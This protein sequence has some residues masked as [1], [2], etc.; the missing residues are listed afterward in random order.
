MEGNGELSFDEFFSE[1]F[2]DLL[3]PEVVEASANF[4]EIVTAVRHAKSEILPCPR[5]G[6]YRSA[7]AKRL[8]DEKEKRNIR[9]RERRAK[10]KKVERELTKLL[11][12]FAKKPTK[13]KLLQTA[14]KEIQIL[15]QAVL[16]LQQ[17]NQ[18][19]EMKLWLKRQF[20]DP[21]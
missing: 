13:L 17:D 7:K 9:E 15:Q 8:K 3:F 14:M 18:H 2:D 6:T 20:H 12:P 10:L 16:T 5:D 1:R 4:G 19:A 11:P 21:S